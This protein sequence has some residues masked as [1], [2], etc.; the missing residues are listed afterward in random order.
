VGV[1]VVVA[2]SWMYASKRWITEVI[3]SFMVSTFLSTVASM[4]SS[5]GPGLG[6]RSAVAVS[7]S[8]SCL[9]RASSVATWEPSDF[10]RFYNA[11]ASEL[12]V[13]PSLAAASTSFSL[14]VCA[15]C[16]FLNAVIVSTYSLHF[17]L[18]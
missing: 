14:L 1:W 2:F 6:I 12:A 16:S 10:T 9:L 7:A 8:V 18:N 3:L 4:S 11:W 13:V 17:A 5:L 15:A